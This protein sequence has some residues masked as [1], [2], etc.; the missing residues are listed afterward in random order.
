MQEFKEY[1][2]EASD[3]GQMKKLL[4]RSLPKG[5]LELSPVYDDT[6]FN[7][8]Y[9]VKGNNITIEISDEDNDITDIIIDFKFDKDSNGDDV[10]EMTGLKV[11]EFEKRNRMNSTIKGFIEAIEFYWKPKNRIEPVSEW[12]SFLNIEHI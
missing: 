2:I 11:K 1:L 10:I 4:K 12:E 3:E 9:K 6:K 5:S 7:I 8:D